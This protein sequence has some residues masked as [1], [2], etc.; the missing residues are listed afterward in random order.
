MEPTSGYYSLIQFC[1][2]ASRAEG[3]NVG[4]VLFCPD[5]PYLGV[6]MSRSNQR[7]RRFFRGTTIDLDRVNAAKRAF[8]NR[9]RSAGQEFS[10]VKDLESFM[11]AR[12]NELLSVAL[13]PVKVYEPREALDSLYAELVGGS[14][15]SDLS[16]QDFGELR[17]AFSR[18]G[19]R[20]RIR[21]DQ[22]VLVPV[23][24][25]P[26]RVRYAYTNGME[27]LV[28][29]V[30]FGRGASTAPRLAL[31][32]DLLHKYA[33]KQLI[34]VARF[35]QASD[36]GIVTSLFGEYQTRLVQP[37][38]IHSFTEEVARTAHE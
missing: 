22:H 1:P 10:S 32:G 2:D 23:M 18:P 27:N 34:V 35:E 38:E 25:R 6:R 9:L 3:A 29:P 14:I 19:L 7:I 21:F 37:E 24:N 26:L 31:E 11:R 4:V 12:G 20:E 15:Q 36:Q 30:L 5:M 8:A 33:S 28:L 13:R 16:R 17:E